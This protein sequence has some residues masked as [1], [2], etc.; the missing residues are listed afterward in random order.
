MM[1]HLTDFEA[2]AKCFRTLTVNQEITA[3]LYMY[4][5]A[6]KKC[7]DDQVKSSHIIYHIESGL[8]EILLSAYKP[9][10]S[11]IRI[12]VKKFI[13]ISI[14]GNVSIIIMEI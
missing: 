8:L 7:L 4:I 12:E 5:K 10:N 11:K 3:C 14:T 1:I 6:I 9:T 2:A 13:D